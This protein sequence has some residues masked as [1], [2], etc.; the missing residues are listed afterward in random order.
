MEHV[1]GQQNEIEPATRANENIKCDKARSF[2][3]VC[4]CVQSKLE[5]CEVAL[6]GG[7]VSLDDWIWYFGCIQRPGGVRAY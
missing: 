3:D 7:K 4:L 6:K 5:D 2:C 1:K